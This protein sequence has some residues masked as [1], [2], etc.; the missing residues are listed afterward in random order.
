MSDHQI[1]RLRVNILAHTQSSAIVQHAALRTWPVGAAFAFEPIRS[2]STSQF[3]DVY[4]HW[5][6]IAS[7]SLTAPLTDPQPLRLRHFPFATHCQSKLDPQAG[8]LAV[9]IGSDSAEL[10]AVAAETDLFAG[11]RVLVAE[12]INEPL[13][14]IRD[15]LVWHTDRHGA[16]AVL[17]VNR[18]DGSVQFAADIA[19]VIAAEPKLTPLKRVLVLSVDHPLGRTDQGGESHPFN[20]PDAP[21]KDRMEHPEPDPKTSRLGFSILY[22]ML[23][24]RY[25]A[26]ARAVARLDTVDLALPGADGSTLF[27][28]LE[29]QHEAVMSLSGERVYPWR[30][31]SSEVAFGDHICGRF[32]GY[33]RNRSWAGVPLRMPEDSI[34]MPHRVL[35][36]KPETTSAWPYWRCM[37]LRVDGDKISRI[38]PKTSLQEQDALLEMANY[39]GAQPERM[40]EKPSESDNILPTRQVTGT[41]TAIVTT[42]KNEG[43]FIMEWLAYHRAIGVSD[44]LVYTN[45]C[46]DGTDA[47]LQLLMDKGYLQW[48]ENPYLT[49]GMKPQHAALDAA[50]TE[51]LIRNADWVICMD[52]DEYIAVHLEDGTLDALYKA[53]PDANLISLTWRLFG[54]D[55]VHEYRDEFIT[56]TFNRAAREIANKPHQ[57]WGFKTLYKNIGAFKKLGVHRPKG[58]RPQ[59]L[60]LINWVNGSGRSMPE[61]QWRNA[62]RSNSETFGYDMVSLNHY[63]V[64]SAESFLVKRDRGRVNHV[65]RDQGAAYWFRMN[66]NCVT[67]NRMQRMLPLLKEEYDRIVSDPE[68]AAAH[69]DCVTAHRAKIDE[70]KQQPKYQ[71]FYEELTSARM[72]KLARLHGHFGSNVYLAGPKV[73]PDEIVNKD[74]AEEFHYTVDYTAETQH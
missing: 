59:A 9:R 6:D 34:W 41:H 45:D 73:I 25:L 7:P 71:E 47:L 4:L 53:I 14:V 63:A 2:A 57:A 69:Q 32:D 56:Q 66:H 44:F 16:E 55:E 24:T 19:C 43:P 70:L 37:A 58:L 48:R 35:G 74:P 10:P 8:P 26:Q 64:R 62:W 17:I 36:P 13:S 15:W 11:L 27:S 68:I 51:P 18:S 28:A 29:N 72:E 49:S 23:R 67:D 30:M 20:L 46:T 3:V 21:G 50:G 61:S 12:R 38:V 42:M 22:D 31:R 54:N 60:P 52:V 65:D 33:D 5:P 40:P 39:F 1:P